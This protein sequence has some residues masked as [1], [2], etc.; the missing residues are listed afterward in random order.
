MRQLLKKVIQLYGYLIAALIIIR[1]MM[2]TLE[3]L[4][5]GNIN[6]CDSETLK[7]NP[8]DIESI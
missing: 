5:Y 7:R 1:D 8:R 3:N 2:T 6:P 4:Y